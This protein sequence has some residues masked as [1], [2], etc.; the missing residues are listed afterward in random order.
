MENS[1]IRRIMYRPLNTMLNIWEPEERG[2][3]NEVWQHPL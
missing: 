2:Y 1:P 3:K